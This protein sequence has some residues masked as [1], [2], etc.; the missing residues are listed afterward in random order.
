MRRVLVI[1]PGGA[2]KTTVARRLA[3]LTALP[4]VHLDALYWRPGWVAPSAS[5]WALVVAALVGREAWILDGNY[6]ATLDARLAA[7]D[8]VVFLD[9]PRGRCL[10][11]ALRRSL[12]QLGR[13]R[14]EVAPGCP[15]RV[16]PAFLWWIW[17]YATRR[18]PTVLRQ[19]DAARGHAAVHVLRDDGEVEAFLREVA[20]RFP[21]GGR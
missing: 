10:W 14:A 16:D 18:R 1:G 3:T 12:S 19:L 15:E 20:G 8:T 4:L 5:E 9:L 7:C 2:G 11:R 17:T 13:T 21:A 6:G